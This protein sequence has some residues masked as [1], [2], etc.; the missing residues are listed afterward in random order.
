[1]LGAPLDP[2][3]EIAVVQLYHPVAPRAHQV[4][5][6]RVGAQPVADLSGVVG[7]RVDRALFVKQ[8]EGP[9]DGGQA[10][11]HSALPQPVV[12]LHRSR[13]IRLVRELLDY[14]DTL[15]SLADAL[16]REK[17]TCLLCSRH[18]A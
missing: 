3:V 18:V 9:V 17:R 12:E 10:D 7:H 16:A 1:M 6:V 2:G 5:V 8:R 14:Q 15:R 4:V 13:V 11:V